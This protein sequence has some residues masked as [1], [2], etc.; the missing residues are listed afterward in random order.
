MVL[1]DTL[2]PALQPFPAMQCSCQLL[3]ATLLTIPIVHG[4]ID[5]PESGSF[6]VIE[7]VVPLEIHMA[8]VQAPLPHISFPLDHT[9]I[10]AIYVLFSLL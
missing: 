8:R 7:H 3:I 1:R 6:T 9:S 10:S 5:L 4:L 2:L